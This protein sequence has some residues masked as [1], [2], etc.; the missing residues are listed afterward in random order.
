MAMITIGERKFNTQHPQDISIPIAFHDSVS[1]F[2]VG[3][4]SKAAYKAGEFIGD[5]SQGGSCN[6][7]DITINPHCQATHTECV[8]H[9]MQDDVCVPDVIKPFVGLAQLITVEEGGVSHNILLEKNLQEDVKALIIRTLPNGTDKLTRSYDEAAYMQ[10]DAMA[11]CNEIGIEHLLVDFPS[12]DPMEDGGK[13]LAHRT[14]WHVEEGQ[15]T[16]TD[17]VASHKSITELIYVPNEIKDG[18]YAL[19]LQFSNM[20]LDGVVSRPLLYREVE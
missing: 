8:G 10:V 2:G 17:S 3:L 6:C 14:F 12:V 15:T 9:I 18:L 1:A 19:N 13:L 5:V 11:Y 16:M 4:P 20:K 7:F